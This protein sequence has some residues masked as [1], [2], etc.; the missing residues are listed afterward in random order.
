MKYEITAERVLRVAIEFESRDEANAR[1][2]AEEMFENMILNP[3]EFDDGDIEHD[4]ALAD[5]HGKT[6]IDWA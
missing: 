5:E 3:S 1:V 4:Y 2:K 6:I